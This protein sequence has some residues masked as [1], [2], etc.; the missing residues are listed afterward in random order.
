VSIL[1]SISGHNTSE[2]RISNAGHQFARCTRCSADLIEIDSRWATA[3]RG[4][5]IVWKAVPK[6][7]EEPSAACEGELTSAQERE[8]ASP[9]HPER[10]GVDRRVNRY[11]LA[12][13]GLE[14]RRK[15][16]RRQNF[17]KKAATS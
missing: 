7:A 17:G 1:C 16:D 10:R 3:P 4:F 5:R 15:R 12:Y 8:A 14:R 2:D 13:T 11:A 6:T 9:K